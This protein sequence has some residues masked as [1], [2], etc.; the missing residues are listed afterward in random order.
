MGQNMKTLIQAESEFQAAAHAVV[1]ESNFFLKAQKVDVLIARLSS[2]VQVAC[3][4]IR[5]LQNIVEGEGK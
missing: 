1:S 2:L 5:R 3:H 4:E